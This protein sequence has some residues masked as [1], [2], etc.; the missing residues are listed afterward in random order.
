MS[1]FGFDTSLPRDRGHPAAAP[2]FSQ[3]TDHF[4]GLSNVD[5][6]DDDDGI[7]FEDTYDGLGDKLDEKDDAFND[8]TFG[9]L[10]EAIGKDFD[11]HGATAR[12]ADAM[13]EEHEVFNRSARNQS[14][15]RVAAAPTQPAR[16]EPPTHVPV[17]RPDMSLWGSGPTAAP[18][19]EPQPE[20]AP[21]APPV[22]RKILSLEE[23]EAQILANNEQRHQSSFQQPP[24]QGRQLPPQHQHIPPMVGPQL[25]Q[26]PPQPHDLHQLQSQQF[27]ARIQSM[28]QR[29]QTPPQVQHHQIPEHHPGA[30]SLQQ[31][32]MQ[33]MGQPLNPS[34]N[35][36]GMTN[37]V[38]TPQLQKMTEAEKA[39]FLEEESKRLKR[40]HKIAQLA[41]YNGLMTPADKNFITRI[42]L[43]HLVSINNAE[44]N[45]NEDFY[46]IVHSAIRA[47]T[48]PQ[49]P[50]NQFAQTYLFRQSARGRNRQQDNHLQRMEQQVQRAVA[51]AK[52]RP[53]ASQLVLEG[54]LGK[55]SFS[56]V[57]T[58]RP[59]LNIKKSD[60]PGGEPIRRTQ[61]STFSS[62]DRKSLLRAIENVYDA[63]LELEVHER[64]RAKLPILMPD[65][66]PQQA[67]V[68]W[69]EKRDQLAAKLWKETKIMEPIDPTS[70]ATHPF[71]AILSYSK[72]KR[73]VQ[74]I[75]RHLDPEQRVTV[76]TMIVV[77]L[78]VLDVVK[79]GVY[80]PDETQLPSAV[81]EEIEMFAASV[82]PPLL[83]Y[84]YEAPLSIV[85][86]LLG[87]L[88]ERVDV[89]AVSKTK[90]GL[91]FLTMFSSRAE[92][93]KQ[94]GGAPENELQQWQMMYDRLFDSLQEHWMEC[95]PPGMFV[96]DVYVWQFLASIA[97]GAN[98]PQQQ[99]L[100]SAVKDRVMENVRASKTLPP[101][102]GA[103]KSA[104]VNLFMR[105]IGLDVELLG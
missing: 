60:A 15:A 48:N 88:L 82:L 97:V 34:R 101:E 22:G 41:R 24:A 87:I 58:P 72:M 80:L 46:Y 65:Q 70:T 6:D 74:R 32:R 7:D 59:M 2:G 50:L 30:V 57:K 96:D 19:P 18:Q 73:A 94:A 27:P 81:R 84:V 29:N 55:I 45:A 31:Q 93:V 63:L 102:L 16:V 98:M 95:F 3:A 76:L 37:H 40:N 105:A 33:P 54:S 89:V 62:A 12:V 49:Q 26:Y 13:E 44:D 36:Y 23:V 91:A 77:H 42:Q 52:A 90:I 61:H 103:Q 51:A 68:E 104:N 17:L 85:I 5:D 78:G 14:V 79:H 71:I 83:G 4:A 64:E 92:I 35:Q 99:A 28:L 10:E 38:P 9:A 8:V 11:F 43:Q 39:R 20:P 21:V 69:A 1:F 56:N 53:K 67:H 47:R 66:Q 25:H 100:V 75:F 86:G